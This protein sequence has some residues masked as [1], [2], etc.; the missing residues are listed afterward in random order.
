MVAAFV[1][2]E[3]VSLA[4]DAGELSS[5]GQVIARPRPQPALRRCQFGC[6][7]QRT[8][9]QRAVSHC[10]AANG[11]L[12]GPARRRG[13]GVRLRSDARDLFRCLRRCALTRAD[14][15]YGSA[16]ATRAD[17]AVGPRGDL[18]PVPDRAAAYRPR[19]AV[20]AHTGR[21][22]G[23]RMELRQVPHVHRRTA[24]LAHVRAHG[25][26]VA[27]RHRMHTADRVSGRVVHR[28]DCARPRAIRAV[29]PVPDSFLGERD[30]PYAG[31]DDPAARVRRDPGLARPFGTGRHTTGAALP[32]CDDPGRP[33]LHIGAVHG[34]AVDQCAGD[35]RRFA[36][37]GR[38]RSRRQRIVHPSTDRAARMPRRE[39]PQAASSC[40]C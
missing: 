36:D 24:V 1:R 31:L 3:I 27:P 13:R 14:Q 21:T 15:R 26:D 4:R 23:L 17:P 22:T 11:P 29:H 16:G 33:G 18:A 39:S 20:I 34:R 9:H 37:R 8:E 35:S 12:C 19:G 38:L 25:I 28:E 32:R 5:F 40:S 30:R 10:I 2:P 6:A 7:G